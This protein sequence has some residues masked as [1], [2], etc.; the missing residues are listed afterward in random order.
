MKDTLKKYTLK[1]KENVDKKGKEV[2]FKIGDKFWAF[3]RKGRLTKGKYSKLQMKKVG[4]CS[5]L[6]KIGDNAY[7]ISLPPTL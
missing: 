6:N 4:P 3:L 5:I 7:E 2:H 1:N